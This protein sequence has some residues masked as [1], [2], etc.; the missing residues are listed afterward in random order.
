M[1]KTLL[2]IFSLFFLTGYAQENETQPYIEVTGTAEKLIV[3]DEIYISINLMERYDGKKKYTV[4]KQEEELKSAL[5][6]KN[7][8]LN[9]LK[10]SD[11]QSSYVKVKWSK[12][13]VL[14]QKQLELKVA[15]AETVGEVFQILDELD[16]EDAQISRVDHSKMDDFK[17]EVKIEAIRAAK[18]KAFYLLEAIDEKPGQLLTVY[19]NAGASLHRISFHL[20]GWKLN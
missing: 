10:L 9:N 11:S 17:K 7:I 13:D 18:E 4:E 12:K 14:N 6:K 16:I 19:E 2:V 1:K 8:D 3:P 5:S 20:S 15:T